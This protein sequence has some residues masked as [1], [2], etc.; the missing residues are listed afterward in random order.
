VN[1]LDAFRRANL[2]WAMGL[3]DVWNDPP[4]DVP[5]LHASIREEFAGKLEA[6]KNDPG[7]GCPLGWVI[8]GGGGTG[9]THLLGS[10]RRE[11]VRRKAA[12]VLVDMTDVRNFWESVLQGF[13]DSLQESFSSQGFQY[14]FLLQNLIGRL[15]PNKPVSEI[16]HILAERKS[17]DLPGDIKKVLNA[18]AQS[19]AKER[20]DVRKR[21]LKHQNVVRALICLN[22]EDFAVSSLGMT[23]LQGQSIEPADREAFGFTN[24]QEQPRKIVEALSWF[25]S[26]SGPTVLAFDQLDPIVT[27]L[28]YRKLGEHSPE[29][30]SI[31]ESII[32]EIGGGL[33]AMRGTTRKTLTVVSCVET[34]WEIL[35]GTAVKN[36]LD[37]FEPAWALRSVRSGAVARSVV[38]QRLTAAYAEVGYQPKFGSWPFRPEAFE[39]LKNDTPREVLKKCE[40]HRQSCLRK[41]VVTLLETFGPDPNE[42]EFVDPRKESFAELDKRLV[43]LAGQCDLEALREE[44]HEDERLAPL[45]QTAL[46]CLLHE[47]T[48]PD[49]VDGLV[50]SEFTG[51]TTTR[52]LH[53]RLRLIFRKENEREEHFCVRA[54][55]HT[56]ARAY[57]ARL[58]AAMTTSGIDRSLKF[59]RLSVVRTRGIPSGAETQKLT[60]KF[61]EAGGDF[62]L[63]SD[64]ELRTLHAVHALKQAGSPDF[65]EWLRSRQP[66]SKLSLIRS[67]V[68]SPILFD[69]LKKKADPAASR[70]T[71]EGN[72]EATTQA[73]SH[74]TSDGTSTRQSP[75]PLGRQLAGGRIVGTVTMPIGLL[76]KHTVVLAGAGSGKTV[77]LRRIIEEA[78]LRG[79]P[80]VVIDCANDLVTLDEEW[81][82]PPADWL[83]EDADKASRYHQV[84]D[85]VVWT[86]GRESGNPVALEP[87]PDLAAV[88]QDPEELE[89]AVTMVRDSLAS[90][91]APGQSAGSRSKLGVLSSAL[92]FFAKQ[93]GGQLDDFMALLNDLPPQ[94][95]LGVA[96]EVKLARQMTDALKV[97]VETNPMLRS[98][99]TPLDPAV[100][101]G[102][103]PLP[104]T[105]VSVVNLVGLASLEAQRSFLNQLAMTLFVWIKRHPELGSRPLRGL[106]VIDEAK[107][108]VPATS[109]STCKESLTRLTAQA[110]KYHLGLVFA[111]Q[112]PREIDNK[113]IANCSTH[114]YGKV[115][116]PAAIE[117]IRDLIRQKG[118][119]GDDIPR[120]PR[121]QFYVHNADAGLSSP[122]KVVVPLCLSRHPD[123]PLDEAAIMAKARASRARIKL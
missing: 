84:S 15:G 1:E 114:Y 97:A 100:L 47:R 62:L 121:G 53:A 94:A 8:V 3:S 110:R 24:P 38:Q 90:V 7:E 69:E 79:V 80:S 111:T 17:K 29:E 50:D 67:I 85:V 27:Q 78:V 57:Q 31:A 109:A 123:N 12:F 102:T 68:P 83:P 32:V 4:W 44:K 95:G 63:P 103:S 118:G 23:W 70:A 76:E 99:G 39:A 105:R 55:E 120:L 115:N 60:S 21:L 81:P 108:F 96:N 9:K 107:D 35:S 59:R 34:T 86:P 66:L 25:M 49:E 74:E 48:L 33:G 88:A 56:N 13:L 16:L 18:L 10:F 51:G 91:V 82:S 93:G 71:P 20:P 37:R 89:S 75:F 64:Q 58:K 98:S 11:A 72:D 52:P 28:H 45:L 5:E 122:A 14:Q 40:L 61:A 43:E 26:L 101:F 112:N 2:D 30:Q 73:E 6:M 117:V 41:G 54:L 65:N 42:N 22:S 104:R 46:Q 119:S 19:Y 106:L 36:Y 77:L 113:I 87:L 116:S 92:R